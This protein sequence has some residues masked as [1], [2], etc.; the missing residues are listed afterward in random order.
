MQPLHIL[1]VLQVL[2]LTYHCDTF[3]KTKEDSQA[4][5]NPKHLP[6]LNFN[7]FIP[8]T[9]HQHIY[10]PFKH[11][12][13]PHLIS[14]HFICYISFYFISF[15]RQHVEWLERCDCDLSSKPTCTILLCVWERHFMALSLAWWSWQ[16]VLNFSHISI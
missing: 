4:K 13:P 16:T 11:H 3:L 7:R 15:C 2:M 10:G 6:T 12:F 5:I 9:T 1:K 14:F 8:N